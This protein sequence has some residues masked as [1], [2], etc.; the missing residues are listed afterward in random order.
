MTFFWPDTGLRHSMSANECE[1]DTPSCYHPLLTICA[2]KA[3]VTP[4][5]GTYLED[6]GPSKS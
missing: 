4:H 6:C 2:K 5:I 1:I 3:K